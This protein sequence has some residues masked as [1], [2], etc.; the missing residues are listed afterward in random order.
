MKKET[1]KI[2]KKSDVILF[3]V[4]CS[5]EYFSECNFAVLTITDEVK[6]AVRGMSH[7]FS[8]NTNKVGREDSSQSLYKM[9]YWN[10]MWGA[11]FL[12]NLDI[13]EEFFDEAFKKIQD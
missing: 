7:I 1:L 4:F 13:S 9:S 11:D 12:H 5:D 10:P 6:K 8:L 2:V 3:K